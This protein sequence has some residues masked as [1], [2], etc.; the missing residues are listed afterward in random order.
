MQVEKNRWMERFAEWLWA[1]S[2]TRFRLVFLAVA[3][4]LFEIFLVLP[5]A[6]MMPTYF[7]LGFIDTV[8]YFAVTSVAVWVVGA[9]SVLTGSSLEWRAVE[10]WAAGDRSQ[11]ELA[12]HSSL[13]LVRRVVLRALLRL[14]PVVA[15]TLVPYWAWR[16]DLGPWSVGIFFVS[17]VIASTIGLLV[18]GATLDLLWRP[19]RIETAAAIEGGATLGQDRGPSLALRITMIGSAFAA[20]VALFVPPLVLQF[21]SGESRYNSSLIGTVVLVV[22]YG[23]AYFHTIAVVPV[24]R[25]LGDLTAA[26][27]RVG[28]G[29]YSEPLPLTSDD[30][31][32][33]LIGAFNDMQQGLAQRERL[34]SAFGSYV[35]PML[36]ARLLQQNDEL[37]KGERI[38]V[39]VMFVDIRDFTPFAEAN[40]AEDTVVHLNTLFNLI[41][42][43]IAD[44]GGH[45]NKFL[46]DGAM[47]VFG[48]PERVADHADR[49]VA[50]AREIQ[51]RV[52]ERFDGTV[53]IGVGV[54]TGNVIAGTIGG[55]GKLEFTLIGDTVNVAARVEQLTKRTGDGILLTQQTVE[56]LA[57]RPH[58]LIDRGAY[59]LKG[60]VD[61]VTVH[62]LDPA[63]AQSD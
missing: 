1:R 18:V 47:V 33:E 24:L 54:N 6:I 40:T 25:P 38:E 37:F 32:G 44:H 19:L 29:D 10:R 16:A 28:V 60:K 57:E 59:E 45:T 27:R 20:T 22:L 5:I 14:V 48:A 62:T 13:S 49:A 30:D 43:I 51:C 8:G 31:L 41:V 52:R 39:T 61:A 58:G 2:R 15:V 34:R 9:W 42:P 23:S 7:E 50:A 56:S 17:C 12:L 36:A 55:G 11:P 4:G 21:D 53:R 63:L 3:V 35:D 26:A 46:G